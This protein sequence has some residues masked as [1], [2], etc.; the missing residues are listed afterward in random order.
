[1]D[2]SMTVPPLTLPP[3]AFVKD[4]RVAPPPPK[5]GGRVATPPSHVDVILDED[6]SEGEG[7][8]TDP[9]MPNLYES[10]S[11]AAE[12]SDSESSVEEPLEQG[13]SKGLKPSEFFFAMQKAI[14]DDPEFR[15]HMRNV[16]VRD[17]LLCPELGLTVNQLRERLDLPETP[18]PTPPHATPKL[19]AQSAP[20]RKKR[21]PGPAPPKKAKK[22]QGPA[23]VRTQ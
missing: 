22:G 7:S 6:P 8:A 13:V 15:E 5:V 18:R 10:Q 4:G 20:K 1:M 19:A 9:N 12:S 16:G 21:S 17:P 14:K 2:H 3:S 11:S 23:S